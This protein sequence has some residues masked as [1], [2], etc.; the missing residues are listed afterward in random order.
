MLVWECTP[1]R[2]NV[3]NA[4]QKLKRRKPVTTD[5]VNEL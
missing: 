1:P 3:I 2:R 5:T 4:R